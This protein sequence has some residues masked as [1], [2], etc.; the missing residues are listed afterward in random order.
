MKTLEDHLTEYCRDGFTIFRQYLA[1]QKLTA[2]RK[3]LDPIMQARFANDADL[4]RAG[5]G[6]A[7]SNE[8]LTPYLNDHLINPMLLDFAERVIGPYVQ[9]DSYR[10]VG[11]PTKAEHL[12]N[13]VDLWHRDAFNLTE[14][15][16]TYS[17]SYTQEPR[18][19][20]PPMACNCLT[21]LQ[22]M[23]AETG[24]L[25]VIPGSHLDYTFIPEADAKNPHPN[26]KLIRLNAGDMVFT[27]CELLH[28]G[29]LNSSSDIRYFVSIYLQRFGLPH[30]DNFATP[31]IKTILQTAK[32][33]ND[34]R[35]MRLFGDDETLHQRQQ[36]AWQR[37]IEEDKQAILAE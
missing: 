11:F 27:H 17:L 15:W 4:R 12:K 23:N 34:R 6:D 9:L 28:S 29:S 30:R 10:I 24:S 22:D 26:E 35:T 3:I 13:Q 2:L 31:A 1:A 36:A 25:R 37:M 18:P 16:A 7:L 8:P 21:Y 14:T 33:R 32:K 5:I 20:T 19:Y